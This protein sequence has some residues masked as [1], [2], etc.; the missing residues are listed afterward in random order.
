ME[1]IHIWLGIFESED[2]LDAYFEDRFEDDETPINRFA[3]DQ[4]QVFYDHD[5]VERAFCTSGDLYELIDGSS[6]SENY[7]QGVVDAAAQL[8]IQSFNTFILA[9]SNEFDSPT[10][11]DNAEYRLWYLGNFKCQP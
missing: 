8:G 3:A 11:V 9:N 2:H 7:I 1:T 5:W 4:G 10:S 6:Y